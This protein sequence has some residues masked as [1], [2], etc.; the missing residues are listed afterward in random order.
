VRLALTVAVLLVASAAASLVGATDV[1]VNVNVPAPPPPAIVLPAPPKL[2]VVPGIPTVQYAPSTSVDLFFHQSRWYYSHGGYWYAG[3]SYK[4]PWTA[5]AVPGLPAPVVAVP[6]KYYKVPP[7]HL[8]QLEKGQG[9]GK[10][11]GKD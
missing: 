2:V 6:V 3:P 5:V 11:K 1:S 9:K 7:G 4:G 8:K 10:G